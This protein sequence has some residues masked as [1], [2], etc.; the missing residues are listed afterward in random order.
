MFPLA[1]AVG[2]VYSNQQ[3]DRD[4]INLGGTNDHVLDEVAAAWGVN[5]GVVPLLNDIVADRTPRIGAEKSEE[6]CLYPRFNH[7]SPG[8]STLGAI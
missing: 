2:E 4:I 6:G 8:N 1:M 5:D 3:H 7:A